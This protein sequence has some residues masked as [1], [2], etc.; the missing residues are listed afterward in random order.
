[1]KRNSDGEAGPAPKRPRPMGDTELR[2]L[3]YSKVRRGFEISS[4]CVNGQPFMIAFH[5][6]GRGQLNEFRPLEFD[7][8]LS[9]TMR[10]SFDFQV[11]GSII[12]KGG[13]NISKLRTEVSRTLSSDDCRTRVFVCAL[14]HFVAHQRRA[15]RAR[16]MER[17]HG[18]MK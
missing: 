8:W 9:L 16:V 1:M 3:V 13:S 6:R 18:L 15:L 2:L 10:L 4:S 14:L 12:G 7:R 17:C 5:V 11:A